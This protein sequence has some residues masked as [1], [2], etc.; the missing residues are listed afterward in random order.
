MFVHEEQMKVLV[1][2][3]LHAV[4][5]E[6]GFSQVVVLKCEHVSESAEKL[7]KIQIAGPG[8]SDSVGLGWA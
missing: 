1:I 6:E 7:V 3:K 2:S 8:V 4:N 5:K